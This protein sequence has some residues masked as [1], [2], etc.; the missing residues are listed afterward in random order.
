MLEFTDNGVAERFYEE[1]F[2]CADCEKIGMVI[3]M[4][5]NNHEEN[6]CSDCGENYFRCSECQKT[7]S[8]YDGDCSKELCG[9]CL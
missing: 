1:F 5:E 4:E 9:N 6:I 8:N 3:D 2:F 7:V